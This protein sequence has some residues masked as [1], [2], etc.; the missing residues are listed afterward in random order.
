MNKSEKKNIVKIITEKIR[1]LKQHLD[2]LDRKSS[3]DFNNKDSD[4][5]QIKH[6]VSDLNK[7]SDQIDFGHR[8]TGLQQKI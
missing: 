6:I 1:T 7:L 5:V 3:D 2:A 8:P 4:M